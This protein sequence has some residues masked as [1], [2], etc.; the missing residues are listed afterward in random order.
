MP[1]DAD[2]PSENGD[3]Q[4][5]GGTPRWRQIEIMQERR[6][7]RDMLDDFGDEDVEID[8]EI[9]GFEKEHEDYF[10]GATDEDDEPEGLEDDD[11]IDD[12]FEE[13]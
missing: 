12:D 13:D 9:F 2:V 5:P 8:D 1:D 7:L 11:F 3:R 4:Q 6:A 10:R